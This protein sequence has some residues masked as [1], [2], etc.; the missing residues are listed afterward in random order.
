MFE[1]MPF[2]NKAY[3]SKIYAQQGEIKYEIQVI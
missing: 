2:S 1:Q 3:R